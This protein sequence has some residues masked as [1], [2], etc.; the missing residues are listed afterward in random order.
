MINLP[1][2]KEVYMILITESAQ[3]AILNYFSS[4]TI[5]PEYGVRVGVKGGAC[6]ANYLL[7]FDLPGEHDEVHTIHKINLIIDKRHLMYV[8]GTKIDYEIAS[9]QSTFVITK[10]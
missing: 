1:D 6:S 2:K 7:G 3:Q 8:I 5:P 9:G 4:G 10:E